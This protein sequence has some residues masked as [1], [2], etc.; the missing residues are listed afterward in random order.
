L[1][2]H[3]GRTQNRWLKCQPTGDR[4]VDFAIASTFTTIILTGVFERYFHGTYGLQSPNFIENDIKR[5]C[6]RLAES[7]KTILIVLD[8]PSLPFD[9]P[10]CLRRPISFRPKLEC[11]FDRKIHE[12]KTAKYRELFYKFAAIYPAVKIV[13]TVQNFCTEEKCFAYNEHGLLYQG[14]NNHLNIAG[15]SLVVQ[16]IVQRAAGLLPANNPGKQN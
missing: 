10:D 8:N 4:I 14:D 7:N 2:S 1:R 16:S 12:S 3:F 5:T 13:E 6:A 11:S 15:A 9:S